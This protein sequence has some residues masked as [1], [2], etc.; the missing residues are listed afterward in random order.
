MLGT[1]RR[2]LWHSNEGATLFASQSH[3]DPIVTVDLRSSHPAKHQVT[4][5]L[6]KANAHGPS[7]LVHNSSEEWTF[8]NH[9]EPLQDALII[10]Q[11]LPQ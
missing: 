2:L 11:S 8:Q 10:V 1:G 7:Q 4:L 5:T 9:E 3:S 6:N